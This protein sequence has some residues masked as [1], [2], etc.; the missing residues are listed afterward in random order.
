VNCGPVKP[1]AYILPNPVIVVEVV[2]PSSESRDV[3][4][5]M[6]DYFAIKS[7]C[8]YLIVYDDRHLVV[9]HSRK[10][11]NEKVETTFLTSGTIELSPPGIVL[12]V[13]DFLGEVDR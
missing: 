9:H 12:E 4:E 6:I 13:S 5:K 3:H 10:N 1:D 8:H 11:Y 7:I 2:S